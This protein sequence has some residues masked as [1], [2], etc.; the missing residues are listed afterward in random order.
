MSAGLSPL[1]QLAQ[2]SGPVQPA[3][4]PA[5]ASDLS[6]LEQLVQ[7]SAKP[8]QPATPSGQVTNDVGQMVVTPRDG[9]SFQD[10]VNR[11]KALQKGREASGT[12]QTA[13]D[14]E[15][16]TIPK[17]TAQTLAGAA[18]IGAVGPAVMAVPGEIA[19][20]AL[21]HLAGNVLPG[22]EAQAAK[23]TLIHALPKVAQFAKTIGEL[24]IGA[25]GLT[26][27]FKTLMGEGK[28]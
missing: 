11:A 21:G 27:L 16:A 1:E 4:Q 12:Q 3:Q 13:L 5:P 17:K 25:G 28:K 18:T 23:Q 14:A 22:M 24:G 19:D 10:T 20:F 6:P 15:T 8:T 7:Q 2:Q 9:E 26:Y